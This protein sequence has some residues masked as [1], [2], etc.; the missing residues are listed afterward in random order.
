MTFMFS[1]I[2]FFA[3]LSESRRISDNRIQNS[4]QNDDMAYT[5]GAAYEG[6]GEFLRSS[7]NR[8][9]SADQNVAYGQQSF[10]FSSFRKNI[11]NEQM[12]FAWDSSA[13]SKGPSLGGSS[14]GGSS[15][16][17]GGAKAPAGKAPK[18]PDSKS[19]VPKQEPYVPPRINFLP[20]ELSMEEYP[21]QAYT[22]SGGIFDS[23]FEGLFLNCARSKIVDTT[24]S[25]E[26]RKIT[27]GFWCIG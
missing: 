13:S 10:P 20:P 15:S 2:L 6:R 12:R 27:N 19:A 11:R 5:L 8:V 25:G 16:S 24:A 23:A 9:N 21:F 7:H 18:A 14:K 17:K 26:N 22:L 3:G 1:I 4:L